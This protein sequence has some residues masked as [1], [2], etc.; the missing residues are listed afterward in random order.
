MVGRVFEWVAQRRRPLA[1]AAIG[2][3]LFIVFLYVFVLVVTGDTRPIG[4]LNTGDSN[5][6]V[7]GT[8]IALECL[9]DG[10]FT[11]CG[12]T[13]GPY[14]LLQYVPAA[15]LIQIG[16]SDDYVLGALGTLSFVAL[17][18][19]LVSALFVF[20]SRPKV[21]ALLFLM[22]LPTS[23]M[24]QATSAFGEGLTSCLVGG[25]VLAAAS[26]RPWLLFVLVAVA[27]LGKETLAPF[28]VLLA[29]ICARSPA[30]GWLPSR[31]LTL[32]AVGGGALGTVLSLTFN[33]FR[34]GTVRN[35]SYLVDA[36]RTPGVARKIEFFGG[37]IASPASGVA[38][39]WPFLTVIS[40][41][42]VALGVRRISRGRGGLRHALPILAVVAVLLAW[43]AAL[44]FW[45]SPFGW[46]AY[47][48][49]LEVPLLVGC[50]VAIAH[51]AGDSIV[52]V[53]RQRLVALV[54]AAFALGFGF[55]QLTAPWRWADAMTQLFRTPTGACLESPA[56][57]HPS[58]D[59]DLYYRCISEMMWRRSPVVF[60]ELLANPLTTVAG[61]AAVLGA[62]GLALMLWDI[63]APKPAE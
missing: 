39:F 14:P 61:F 16:F 50:A 8:H 49:R 17:V 4:H 30:D 43:F 63:R 20:R 34:F 12:P 11:D 52:R 15:A 21:A 40:V 26:R 19:L 6:L 48:P 62:I 42:G 1:L 54:A 7:S 55:L 45:F 5:N 35:E 23:L 22:L 57:V 32:A 31:R 18:A 13:V 44:S 47:G 60:D 25:A 51:V 29:L 10:R 53:I 33:V 9:R 41:V 28:V 59:P 46:E 58:V 24:Y 56:A 37:I 27:A 38:W 3:Y 36:Y 2:A